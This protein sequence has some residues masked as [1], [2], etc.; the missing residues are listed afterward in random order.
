MD[1]RN[2]IAIFNN[3]Y[4]DFV[5]RI[6]H[7]NYIYY[8]NASFAMMVGNEIFSGN[9]AESTQIYW[10]EILM[11]THFTSVTSMLRN[12]KWINGIELS[13]E[14]ENLLVFAS[15][16][17][18]FL[19]AVS[20]SYFSLSSAATGLAENFC[21]IEK[22]IIGKQNR[23]FTAGGLEEDLLHFEFASKNDKSGLPNNK[24]LNVSTYIESIDLFGDAKIKELYS[25]LCE[26]SHPSS[27]SVTCFTSTIKDGDNGYILTCNNL[28]KQ[29][30][31]TILQDYQNSVIYLLKLSFATPLACL[32][33]MNLFNF[34]DVKSSYIQ[35]C[36]FNKL[37]GDNGWNNFQK[38]IDN[39]GEIID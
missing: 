4:L 34:E 14:S 23:F 33:V 20:D 2:E 18:G 22:S 38:L 17:R 19:E 3:C 16:L 31:I 5:R 13:I 8:N 28:D 15:T 24:P 29:R 27:K 12:N 36:M 10:K 7:K 35:D 25:I 39:S 30:I 9:I 6:E 1:I 32:K 26:L 37:I 21:N 11:R